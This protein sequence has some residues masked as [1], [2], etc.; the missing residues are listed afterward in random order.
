MMDSERAQSAVGDTMASEQLHLFGKAGQGVSTSETVSTTIQRRSRSNA[1]ANKLDHADLPAHNW[2]RFVLSFA[3]HLVREYLH[4][5]RIG[6]SHL[7][8]DPFCGTGTTLVECKKAGVPSVGIEAHPMAHFAATAKTNWRIN[9]QELISHA[10]EVADKARARLALDGIEDL[11]LQPTNGRSS[12]DLLTLPDEALRLLLKDSISPLPLHKTIV[13]LASLGAS[14]SAEFDAHERL[15]LANALVTSIG[16]LHFGPEVGIGQ[17]KGDAPVVGPW[18]DQVK[19]IA[20]DIQTLN[21][22]AHVPATVMLSDARALGELLPPASVDAVFTSPPYPNEKDYTRTMRLE[23]VLLGFITNKEQLRALK[24]SLVRSNTRGVYVSD[25]DDE[26]VS[27]FPEIADLAEQ[28]EARRE[29]LGKTSGFERMY[30]RVTLLYFGGMA[31]HLS[32]LRRCLRPGAMLGYVVG[33]QASYLRVMIKTGEILARIAESLGYVVVDIDLFRTRL[34]TATKQQ[35]R[36]EVV[37]LR[38]P[39]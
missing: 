11:S 24:K 31:R 18:L 35:L 8:L 23:S 38:W 2:Y 10:S 5:F 1:S 30:H 22:R 26:W 6:S 20:A 7:V 32:S 34:S 36:E 9:A 13:L 21:D 4:R 17:I 39:G 37:V 3:P 14:R 33:D 15:V 25:T 16:N 29:S 27:E 12:P 28:I 19:R